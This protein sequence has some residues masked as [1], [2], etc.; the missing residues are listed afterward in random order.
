MK[1]KLTLIYSLLLAISICV[2]PASALEVE[3]RPTSPRAYDG[4]EFVEAYDVS[5]QSRSTD[6]ELGSYTIKKYL[7][8]GY[9]KFTD[10]SFDKSNF[11]EDGVFKFVTNLTTDGTKDEIKVGI[12]YVDFWGS[13]TFFA[14]TT[15]GLSDKK[16]FTVT[17]KPGKNTIY[18]GCIDNKTGGKVYG[19]FSIYAVTA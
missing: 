7:N 16:L 14:S 8:N 4:T 12:A 19:S 18:Y 5:V 3:G 10:Q 1:K 13:D 2:V 9:M 6:T 11:P 17:K 15:M